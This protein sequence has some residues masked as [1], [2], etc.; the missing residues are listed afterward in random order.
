MGIVLVERDAEVSIIKLNRPDYLNAFNQDLIDEVLACLANIDDDPTIRAVVITG[1]G[2]AFCAGADLSDVGTQV[3]GAMVA[4]LLDKGYNRIVRALHQMS[5]PVVSAINGLAAGGGVGLALSADAVF[6]GKSAYFKQVFGPQLAIVPDVGSTWYLPNL[7]G[8]ARALP[9]M[10]TGDNLPAQ[11][12]QDWGL[13]W[14]CVDDDALM[15]AAI[16]HARRIGAG[17]I[18]AFVTIR[19]MV[20]AASTRSLNDQLD[21]ERDA[22]GVLCDTANFRE[23][24]SAFLA[25]RKPAFE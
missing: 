13:I 3:T 7:I 22:N 9:L 11:D 16:A 24:V 21:A 15:D 10:M 6:A 23:G 4:E 14:K 5:K 17:P 19:K 2:R 25:K 12:A 8:R 18:E 1:V 20:N